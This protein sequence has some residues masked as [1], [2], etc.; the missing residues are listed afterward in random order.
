MTKP[1]PLYTQAELIDLIIAN[2]AEIERLESYMTIESPTQIAWLRAHIR[3]LIAMYHH[4]ST[5]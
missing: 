4:P 3:T 2:A 1:S 5:V